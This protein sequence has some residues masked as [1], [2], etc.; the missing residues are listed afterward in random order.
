MNIFGGWRTYSP[1][2]L[3]SLNPGLEREFDS[4]VKNDPWGS[5]HGATE[6]NLTSIHEDTGSIPGLARWVKDPVLQ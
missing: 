2:N 4:C 1:L 6:T 3:T 5:R